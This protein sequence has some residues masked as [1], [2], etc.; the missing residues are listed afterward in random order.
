MVRARRGDR[1][2]APRAREAAD[3]ARGRARR[4]RAG[5]AAGGS[6]GSGQG[7]SPFR[8]SRSSPSDRAGRT[9]TPSTSVGLGGDGERH[10]HLADAVAAQRVDERERARD[11]ADAAVEPELAEHADAVERRVG[12]VARGD[13]E[14][15]GDRELEAGAGLAHRGRREVDGDAALRP[16]RARTTAA[17]RGPARATRGPRC[18]ADRRRSS[19]AARW[20]RGLRPGPAGRR[21]R[22]ASHCGSKQAREVSLDD[23]VM[24]RG[25]RCTRPRTLRRN[26]REGSDTEPVDRERTRALRVVS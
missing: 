26:L 17:R 9:V 22:A 25:G 21:C 20:R 1:E 11:R 18:R 5:R 14:P 8:H 2:R 4:D 16:R 12:E 3:L 19:R 13:E 24:S 23:D 6:G 15:E 10:D 7:S